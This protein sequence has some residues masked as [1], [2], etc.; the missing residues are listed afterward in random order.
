MRPS[1]MRRMRSK[2]VPP[3][4]KSITIPPEAFKAVFTRQMSF[5]GLDVNASFPTDVILRRMSPTAH[6]F[7][8]SK[9]AAHTS[10]P[11]V[12]VLSGMKSG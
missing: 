8:S 9:S 3:S 5:A 11:D 4:G 1:S 12:F 10:A 6:P 2:R 7:F